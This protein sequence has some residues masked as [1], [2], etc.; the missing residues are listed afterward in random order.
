MGEDLFY[1]AEPAWVWQ[2]AVHSEPVTQMSSVR[3][4]RNIEGFPFPG[5]CGKS[6]L[7]DSAAEALGSLGRSPVWGDCDF[8]L[9][10]NLGEVAK[11]LLLEN[12]VIT[13]KFMLGGP[14]RFLLRDSLGMTACMIN[15]DDHISIAST[16]PGLDLHT[17]LR[18]VS[19]M[20]NSIGIKLSRDVVLGYLT[21]DPAYVGT[22]MTATVMFH[23]PAL[24]VTDDISRVAGAFQRDWNSLELGKILP[25]GGEPCGSFYALSNRITLSVTPEEIV[26]NV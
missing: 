11:Y 12:N 24:D 26:R 5:R 25:F 10:D 1:S 15:E 14:G 4:R 23:L 3:V 7:Y 8:R 9:M 13:P 20:E 22:G 21:A 19:D 16:R 2:A 18:T 17:A 6:E